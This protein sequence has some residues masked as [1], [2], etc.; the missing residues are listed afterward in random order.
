[1]PSGVEEIILVGAGANFYLTYI[2]LSVKSN[3]KLNFTNITT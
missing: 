1:M 3:I 2:Y